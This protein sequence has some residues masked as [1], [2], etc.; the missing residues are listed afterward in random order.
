MNKCKECKCEIHICTDTELN[1]TEMRNEPPL[2]CIQKPSIPALKSFVSIDD[3][4]NKKSVSALESHELNAKYP[5]TELNPILASFD[6]NGDGKLEW[7]DYKK[8]QNN[9]DYVSA[10]NK[11]TF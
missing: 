11:C 3:A 10:N 7:E 1:E 4:S 2:G 9:K 5:I 8:Y 6:A